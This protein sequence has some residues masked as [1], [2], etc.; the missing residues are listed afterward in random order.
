MARA[1]EQIF[2]A[3]RNGN[4]RWLAWPIGLLAAVTLLFEFTP[5][6][7]VVQ[8]QLFDFAAGRW[9][10]DGRE[11]VARLLFYTGPKLGVIACGLTLLTLAAGPAGWRTRL[12]LGHRGLW[13]AVLSL[14]TVPALA[15]LGKRLTNV[16]C[17][18]EVRRY[19]GTE[20]YV[21]L[22]SAYPAG[23]P[24][25]RKGHCFPAGHA[26]G[27]FALGGMAWMRATR[28]WRRRAV[29]VGLAAGSW[30]AGYQMLKG[31]HYLSHTLT[32]LLLAWLVCLVWR[33]LLGPGR[34]WPWAARRCAGR[35]SIEAL[36][37]PRE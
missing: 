6:D 35:N 7:L 8:D 25:G 27:G 36:A 24:P 33:Q 21:R 31:A 37:S 10:V 34:K 18:S 30:M 3:E 15:G 26:S 11:P 32:T 14:A 17:P 13:I 22:C 2:F 5:L 9:M 12:R 29:L 4:R 23:E 1:D 20:A 16:H 19:G 28:R